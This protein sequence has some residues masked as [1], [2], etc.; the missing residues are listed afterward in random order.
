ME[1]NQCTFFPFKNQKRLNLKQKCTFMQC[2]I[3]ISLRANSSQ[4]LANISPSIME[5][6]A[7]LIQPNP[8][9]FGPVGKPR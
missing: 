2:F 6:N 4:Y 3:N 7:Q 9:L 8:F 1:E 5:V